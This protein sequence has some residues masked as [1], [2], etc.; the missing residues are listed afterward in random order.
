[1]AAFYHADLVGHG[2]DVPDV[3]LGG[4]GREQGDGQHLVDSI[5]EDELQ[6]LP[7]GLRDVLEVLLVA[8]R[9]DDC[10][11]ASPASSE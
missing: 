11:D 3:L 9:Q 2:L 5:D 4:L 7:D 6:L 1:M 10:A 8:A